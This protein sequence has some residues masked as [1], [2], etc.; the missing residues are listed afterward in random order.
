MLN[1][2]GR[3]LKFVGKNIASLAYIKFV[4]LT[5]RSTNLNKPNNLQ[6]YIFELPTSLKVNL[7]NLFNYTQIRKNIQRFIKTM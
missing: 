3:F 7:S 5:L 6:K 2:A 1:I 4:V